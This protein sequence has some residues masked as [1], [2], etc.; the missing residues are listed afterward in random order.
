MV[1]ELVSGLIFYGEDNGIYGFSVESQKPRDW[2][3]GNMVLL[4]G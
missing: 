4:A 3:F 2:S 1:D